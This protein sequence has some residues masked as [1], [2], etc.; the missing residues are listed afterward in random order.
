MEAD[1][2]PPAVPLSPQKR[3][4]TAAAHDAS[5]LPSHGVAFDASDLRCNSPF[6]D[7]VG[8]QEGGVFSFDS[9]LEARPRLGK[10]L[11]M[12]S[13]PQKRRVLHGR[14]YGDTAVDYAGDEL[15]AYEQNVTF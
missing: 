12:D 1:E 10:L 11:P 9:P 13:P 14:A 7:L 3:A 6:L 4:T 15:L 8:A 5:G 2:V